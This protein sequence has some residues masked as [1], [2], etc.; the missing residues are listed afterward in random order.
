[1]KKISVVIPCF[2]SGATIERTV[3]SVKAQTYND[4]EI[5][6]VDD[7]STLPS[8]CDTLLA[9]DGVTLVRQAI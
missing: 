8:T 7:G 3:E 4:F 5:I 6:V 9:L 1:M 2:N